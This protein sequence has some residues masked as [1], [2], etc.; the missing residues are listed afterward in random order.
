ML[1]GQVF[2]QSC[3]WKLLFWLI[4]G[5][6]SLHYPEAFDFPG[7]TVKIVSFLKLGALR[8]VGDIL[9][10]CCWGSCRVY[11]LSKCP[12]GLDLADFEPVQERL[13]IWRV[14]FRWIPTALYWVT[15]LMIQLIFMLPISC[16]SCRFQL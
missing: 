3:I 14:K 13:V 2:W 4:L 12:K 6:E 9:Q 5:S 10:A 15:S 8:F 1:L 7:K 11:D 16:Q